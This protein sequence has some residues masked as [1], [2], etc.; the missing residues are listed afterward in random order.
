MEITDVAAPEHPMLQSVT[1]AIA[2]PLANS[3]PQST[4]VSGC[5]LQKGDITYSI[6][7][8]DKGSG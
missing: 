8:P 3:V 5:E 6:R 4:H 1:G 7:L 2:A